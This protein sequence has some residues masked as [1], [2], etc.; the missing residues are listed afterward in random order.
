MSALDAAVSRTTRGMLDRTLYV[1]LSR[2]VAPKEALG[3][4]LEAHLRFMVALEEEGVL[5]AS[6]PFFGPGGASTGE[7]MTIVRATSPE[8]ARSILERDPFVVAGLRTFD[9]HEWHLME[10]AIQV[11]LHA[12]QQR[13][14]LP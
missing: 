9:L 5:F 1:A 12:S 7:G 8:Q 4:H 13:G 14:M 11:T 3:G 2:L 6:G 10:G